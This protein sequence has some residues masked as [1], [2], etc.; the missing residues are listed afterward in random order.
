[1]RSTVSRI[2]RR[3][4][5][6]GLVLVALT[7]LIR[8]ADLTVDASVDC[9][10]STQT[11]SSDTAGDPEAAR[12]HWRRN[13]PESGIWRKGTDA[14]RSSHSGADIEAAPHRR[15]HSAEPAPNDDPEVT[16]HVQVL[17]L[18]RGPRPRAPDARIIRPEPTDPSSKRPDTASGPSAPRPPPAASPL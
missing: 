15:M 6:I 10:R 9:S 2:A 18:A 11:R 8:A 4:G 1:M 12:E 16:V 14:R 7:P 5:L 3:L 13:S 17:V